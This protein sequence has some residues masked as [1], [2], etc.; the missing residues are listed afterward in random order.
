[1][2]RTQDGVEYTSNGVD[3]KTFDIE[4]MIERFKDV[5]VLGINVL[6]LVYK[7]PV[8]KKSY[9]GIYYPDSSVDEEEEYSSHIGVI[10]KIGP[11]AYQGKQFP[12]GAYVKP[13]DWVIF[14]RGSSLQT[15]YE[16]EP[17]VL[18][19]DFKLKMKIKDPSKMSR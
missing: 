1:M 4:K 8:E 7:K 12:T 15:K 3:L 2:I 6:I 11:D 5:E 9:G 17:I 19:E 10:L 16:D 18:V 14:P 13:G